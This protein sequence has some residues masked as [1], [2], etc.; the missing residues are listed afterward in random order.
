MYSDLVSKLGGDAAASSDAAPMDD[1]VKA[2]DA[3]AAASAVA[4]AAAE[5]AANR[6]RLD[7][8]SKTQASQAG[9]GSNSYY[10]W[11]SKVPQG[12]GAAP[13][14]TPKL[15]AT[16]T[17]KT[18]PT[19]AKAINSYSLLD[20]GEEVLKIYVPLEGEL[21]QVNADS[22]EAEFATRSITITLTTP[23]TLHKLHVPT[24]AHEILPEKCKTKVTKSRKLI[25]TLAKREVSRT[26]KQL[27]AF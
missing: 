13:K 20:E 1:E 3:T 16:E 24:L 5:A 10:Y 2:Q 26:W 6:P 25:I 4:A 8:V 14:P 12:D 19:S 27:R 15:L 9:A 18:G 7:A 21:D 23:S 17:A 11:H 22:I